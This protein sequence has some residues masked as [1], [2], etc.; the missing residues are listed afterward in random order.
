MNDIESGNG[1][2]NG[3]LTLPQQL[4]SRVLQWFERSVGEPTS[5]QSNAWSSILDGRN[6]LI[7][8]PTG[9]GKTLA[10]VLPAVS[11]LLS[12]RWGRGSISVVYI[13]PMRA[14]GAD[15]VR[16][17]GDISDGLGPFPGRSVRKG[18]GRK[19]PDGPG[20][21]PLEIGIRTGDVS[22]YERRKLLTHPPDVLIITPE[23]LLLMLCSGARETLMEVSC[24]ILDELHELAASKRGAML[25]LSLELLNEQLHGR[26]RPEP[27]RIGLSATVRPERTA[28]VFL[29]GYDRSG[30]PRPVNIVMEPE[31]K[32]MEIEVR[33]IRTDDLPPEA[34]SEVILE[35]VTRSIE[36]EK[37]SVVVFQ[38]TRRGAEEMSFAL[39]QKGLEGVS[40]HHGSL[41]PD[42][43]RRAEEGLK[44][45]DLRA[46]IS[47]TS[48]ELGVDIGS[49][50]LVV[51]VASPRSPTR[52][53]QRFG[54]SGHGLK[55]TSRGVILSTS[56]VDLLESMAVLR[57]ASSG[58]IERL[59]PPM[60]PPDVLAQFIV[61]AAIGEDGLDPRRI[62]DLAKRTFQF[63]GLKGATLK[64]IISLLTERL[65]GPK[66]P[67]PRL[68]KDGATGLLQPNRDTKQAFYLNCGTIP[69]ETNYKV[70]D[71]R[72][73]HVVGELSR[74]FAESLFERDVIMLASK[75]YRVTGFSGS[76]VQVREDPGSFPTTPLWT[77]E[78][79][80][81]PMVV[82]R[83]IYALHSRPPRRSSGSSG[84]FSWKMDGPSVELLRDSLQA[85][86]ASGIRPSE[87][88]I[89]VE[90]VPLPGG[91]TAHVVHLPL[92][93]RSTDLFGRVLSYG[94]RRR[95]GAAMD[96]TASDDGIAVSSPLVLEAS[97]LMLSMPEGPLKDLAEEL[98]LSSS[99]FRSRFASCAGRS[100]LVLSRFRG[101]DTGVMYRRSTM[102]RLLATVRSSKRS[103][104]G[105][106]R[107]GGPVDGLRLILDEA[108][109]ESMTEGTDLQRLEDICSGLRNGSIRLE[110][111]PPS[112]A[113]SFLG[114]S[115]IRNWKVRT[116]DGVKGAFDGG[117]EIKGPSNEGRDLGKMS[118]A[119]GG[120]IP[121][122]GA[123][124]HLQGSRIAEDR[125][126][127]L[128]VRGG[129]EKVLRSVPFF[130]HPLD[131]I[132]RANDSD[133]NQLRSA[134]KGG[135]LVPVRACG[136]ERMAHPDW[137]RTFQVLSPPPP[138]MTKELNLLLLE[139]RPVTR[140]EV[141]AASNVKGPEL[142]GLLETLAQSN[143]L[144][145]FPVEARYHLGAPE[146]FVPGPPLRWND[147][148][149]ESE[150][151]KAALKVLSYLGP[152][153][154]TELARM[155]NWGEGHLPL[156][157]SKGLD[158]G[159][160]RAFQGPLGP[161]DL[162]VEGRTGNSQER[163]WLAIP[164]EGGPAAR[165][166]TGP[167]LTVMTSKDP[168]LVITG[169]ATEE[170]EREHV[171]GTL[172][173]LLEAYHPERAFYVQARTSER[174]DLVLFRELSISDYSLVGSAGNMIM[175][176]VKL[177]EHLGYEVFCID[178]LM[179][180]PA[181][182]T[183]PRLLGPLEMG[184]FSPLMT[185][186][187]TVLIRGCEEGR[188]LD[189][190][191]I[192]GEMLSRQGL[193]PES[194]K[195]HPVE[196]LELLGGI[197]DR[198][199][200]LS[201][202]GTSRYPNAYG[203]NKDAIAFRQ[204][205]LW[206]GLG[207]GL[208][209]EPDDHCIPAPLELSEK[210]ESLPEIRDLARGLGLWKVILDQPGPVWAFE[211][212]ALRAPPPPPGS[213]ASLDKASRKLVER[214]LA[215]SRKASSDILKALEGDGGA[216]ELVR[217]GLAVQDAWGDHQFPFD[218][219]RFG[220]AHRRRDQQEPKG[221]RQRKW[222]IRC[223]NAL[224]LFTMGDLIEYSPTLDDPCKVRSMLNELSRGP[225]ARKLYYDSGPVL[226]HGVPEA[227]AAHPGPDPPY[228]MDGTGLTL[229][230]PRDRMAR[231]LAG[232]VRALLSRRQG[233]LVMKGTRC[234]S[235][236]SI[237][238]S[239][240]GRRK[241][242]NEGIGPSYGGAKLMIKKVWMDLRLKRSDLL[243][244][245]KRAFF[246]HGSK[247][248][249]VEEGSGLE[250]LYREM[251]PSEDVP[252]MFRKRG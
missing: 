119:T 219:S 47:S 19:V 206:D 49:V 40:A 193:L 5:M 85:L 14:L 21:A 39:T 62:M 1:P 33:T 168:S 112:S 202:L 164:A 123:S 197:S 116:I 16:N 171:R 102:D 8:S 44:R 94:L 240:Y 38:N 150:Q 196:V 231:V 199:E 245:V 130:T 51:Q 189:R 80:A 129:L 13:S 228:P 103:G 167:E 224:G 107:A 25:S 222:L 190:E 77:G 70:M 187:G 146:G 132:R 126:S 64:A 111:L 235:T 181:G 149:L 128:E 53:I 57:A 69:R 160:I 204:K 12:G 173:A 30:R 96:H 139:G 73:G 75:S 122:S 184:G 142:T 236:V 105:I 177:Y 41:G 72:K 243:R 208:K 144:V 214:L 71:V 136:K 227:F 141:G 140:T 97:D 175:D 207:R 249:T 125:R 213:F 91:R 17:L 252:V 35:G 153:T 29:G 238:R 99:M 26:G 244:D 233:F 182:D 6:T 110:M 2:V 98:V 84:P 32:E 203:L 225:L 220:R 147:E 27:V 31:R 127:R 10:A 15:L 251:G 66:Q 186:K 93:K 36:G 60:G 138:E 152:M 162:S 101:R 188:G 148:R 133:L 20:S 87:H 226:V 59:T 169:D 48:L 90:R 76:R 28:A 195:R 194:R 106:S 205:M 230:S 117:T 65:P 192:L 170:L 247:V 46:I 185:E 157:I 201:R 210:M 4:D 61:G 176:A 159:A 95:F 163:S 58:D 23:N 135:R 83:E 109:K 179:G 143:C 166:I 18:R 137:A 246:E 250:D 232:D 242:G 178:G 218:D 172:P 155:F 79:P 34:V 52:L 43:R 100:L 37:G 215:V 81:R 161:M 151:L 158:E 74:D 180:V 89:P 42:I 92:G 78:A 183:A 82:T 134:L 104:S 145:P 9:S 120:S 67:S 217:S 113:P 241:G 124:S 229:I 223:A 239:S 24:V 191:R 63:R 216:A 174:R 121:S 55:R 22:Q 54:R 221:L 68:R 11:N 7:I 237:V 50:G 114:A 198:W 131:I 165:N 56:R 86:A 115:I 156:G 234:L 248:L 108:L 118:M 209:G 211:E 88:V 45:G 3:D 154:V 212:E 200:L